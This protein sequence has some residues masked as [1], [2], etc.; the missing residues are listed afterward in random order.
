MTNPLPASVGDALARLE[1]WVLRRAS[2]RST[3]VG[4][5]T[6]A[7]NLGWPGLAAHLTGLGDVAPAV[8]A[9]IGAGLMTASTSPRPAPAT[10][11]QKET[12]MSIG[13]EL[14][15]VLGIVIGIM[16]PGASAGTTNL[17]TTVQNELAKVYGAA[18]KDMATAL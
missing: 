6:V 14:K 11:P 16:I 3:Y 2:E 5:G 9:T 1:R 8:L 7:L 17:T 15:H 13:S 18:A 12:D 4:L 10:P